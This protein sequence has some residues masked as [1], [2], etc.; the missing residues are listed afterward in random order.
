MIKTLTKRQTDKFPEYCKKWIERGLSTGDCNFTKAQESVILA[1]KEGGIEPPKR[2]F[3]Y[4]SPIS[5][6][7]GEIMV[8]TIIN[9]MKVKQN[10]K[11]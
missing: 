6:A 9:Y 10:E 3:L 1:Y 2:F 4:D 5:S 8:E 7:L 11:S